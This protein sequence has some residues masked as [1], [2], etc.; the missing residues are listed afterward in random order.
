MINRE[1]IYAALWMLGAGA[2]NLPA[3]IG[4]CV[5]GVTWLQR[6][7]RALFMSEK[8]G[9]AAV[10]RLGAPI[11]WTLYAEFYIYVHSKPSL[12]G[13]RNHCCPVN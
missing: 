5:I 3:R 10:K 2:R 13:T 1:T 7:S 9:H 11:V 12:F 6:S 8:G 4:A